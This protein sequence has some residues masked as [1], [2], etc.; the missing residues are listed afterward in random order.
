MRGVLHVRRRIWNNDVDTPKGGKGRDVPLSDELRAALG[1]LPSRSAKRL[2]FPGDEGAYLRKNQCKWPL[3]R[4]CK[5]AG[6]RRIGWHV[7]RH[8]FASHLI[9]RGVPLLGV[10]QLLGHKDVKMTMRYAHLSPHV[11]RDGVALLDAPSP[12]KGGEAPAVPVSG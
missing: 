8:T 5:Q 7:L 10:Q 2:V 6:L 9:M 12:Q 1:E 3:W 11:A 4:A